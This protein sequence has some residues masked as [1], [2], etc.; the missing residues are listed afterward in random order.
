MTLPLGDRIRPGTD[1]VD[2]YGWVSDYG[3]LRRLLA[4]QLLA[5]GLLPQ[6]APLTDED[7]VAEPSGEVLVVAH[8]QHGLA[9]LEREGSE[10][11]H[12]FLGGHWV[13]A[14]RRLVG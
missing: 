11:P 14:P 10:R 7:A 5:S 6:R 9:Q 13:E 4:G 8:E 2:G 1:G 3:R 12:H